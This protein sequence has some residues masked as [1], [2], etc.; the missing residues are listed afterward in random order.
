MRSC[1]YSRSMCSRLVCFRS[2]QVQEDRQRIYRRLQRK[3]SIHVPPAQN[4]KPQGPG[5]VSRWKSEAV[6][7]MDTR[8]SPCSPPSLPGKAERNIVFV[9]GKP[10]PVQNVDMLNHVEGRR[11]RNLHLPWSNVGMRADGQYMRRS[12]ATGF[13]CTRRYGR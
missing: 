11:S 1:Q 12:A 13:V 2:S 9:I 8:V 6:N 10:H 4:P 7:K 3:G 5:D